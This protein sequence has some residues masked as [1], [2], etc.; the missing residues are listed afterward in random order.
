MSTVDDLL[1]T[2]PAGDINFQVVVLDDT[3]TPCS[4]AL[5]ALDFCNCDEAILCLYAGG[6]PCGNG[7]NDL[8]FATTNANGVAV[9][10]PPAGGICGGAMV[11]IV[12][13]G[14]LLAQRN[15]LA[16]DVNGNFLVEM[17]DFTFDPVLNDYNGD[18]VSNLV[19]NLIWSNHA[20]VF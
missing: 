11:D 2:C 15:V 4:G 12:A 1:L 13:D 3:G 18:G 6:S 14:V 10:S 17:T 7:K 19:D 5:V 16:M 8:L 20:A 9:F